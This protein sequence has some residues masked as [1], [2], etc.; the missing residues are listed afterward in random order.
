MPGEVRPYLVP[1]PS[2]VQWGTWELW[3][4]E[5]W[6]PLPYELEGWDSGTDLVLRRTVQVLADAFTAET[7]LLPSEVRVTASWTS[8]TTDMTDASTPV[9]L[10]SDGS[11][12]LQ[13]RVA[14]SRIAGVL[15]IRT[16][17]AL[18]HPPVTQQLG[19]ARIPGSV[20]TED[21]RGVAL[22]RTTSMF[23]V[24]EVD[25]AG[26]PL[27]P[28]ASWH[29]ETT[30]DFDAP[31][32]GTFQLL[33][34]SRDRELCAAVRNP[35]D[36]RQLA[37]CDELQGGVAMLMLE[38]AVRARDELLERTWASDSVGD[39]FSRLLRNSGLETDI[40]PATPGMSRFRSRV[41]QA[42]R[43]S[44]QGRQFT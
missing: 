15:T 9:P 31:F 3:E 24:H 36:K 30:T 10:G 16:T 17:L 33:L 18:H 13:F 38:I 4:D 41:A 26:T 39:V 27:P 11:A 5:A 6:V 8:S 7:Y 32:L 20:L 2:T 28:D 44:G 12:L 43:R 40:Y 14:G 19:A 22:D 29:L 23:P 35:K 25:F 1:I 37:L 34:N 42:V 21:Q